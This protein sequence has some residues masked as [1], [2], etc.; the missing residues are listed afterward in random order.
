MKHR[1]VDVETASFCVHDIDN[2][3]DDNNNDAQT[4]HF[5]PCTITLGNR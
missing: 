4:D 1:C 5:T 2:D 3:N